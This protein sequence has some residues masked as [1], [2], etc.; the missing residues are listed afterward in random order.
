[1]P[2][3]DPQSLGR[4][5]RGL[6]LR[7]QPRPDPVLSSDELR[8][9]ARLLNGHIDWAARRMEEGPVSEAIIR[10]RIDAETALAKVQEALRS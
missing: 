7:L 8:T 5:K 10:H 6:R 9:I 2:H 3:R 4:N 1:M